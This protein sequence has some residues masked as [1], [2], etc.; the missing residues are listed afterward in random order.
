MNGR[1]SK[2]LV[3]LFLI[4]KMNFQ[5]AEDIDWLTCSWGGPYSEDDEPP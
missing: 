4:S 5:R 2:D 3:Q 1:G